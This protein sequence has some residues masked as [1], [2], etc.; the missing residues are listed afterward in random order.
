[1]KKTILII[2]AIVMMAG[3]STRVMAQTH[4]ATIT[5]DAVA[6]LIV[7]MT[8]NKTAGLNFGTLNLGTGASGAVVLSTGGTSTPS[9]GV[10]LSSFKNRPSVATYKVTG[11]YSQ[12]YALTIDNSIT[13]TAASVLAGVK[14]M[15]VSNLTVSYTNKPTEAPANGSTSTLDATGIDSFKI[16][17]TLTVDASQAGGI[18]NGSFTASVDYN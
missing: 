12:T 1:M 14:T 2:G 4:S 7:P 11:T 8:L 10:T 3:F 6:E 17:G 16:G 18:Y 15:T 13:L 5:N 9:G